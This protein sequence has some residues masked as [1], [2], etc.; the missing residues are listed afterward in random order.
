MSC[1]ARR[2]STLAI[3]GKV[4]GKV[5][6]ILDSIGPKD[7]ESGYIDTLDT[8]GKLINRKQ[9]G[10]SLLQKV[11]AGAI[12]ADKLPVLAQYE[13]AISEDHDSGATLL[14]KD[15]DALISGIRQKVKSLTVLNVQFAE[16]NQ[17]LTTRTAEVLAEAEI[18]KET[19]EAEV[20]DFDNAGVTDATADGINSEHNGMPH[21]APDHAGP[22]D[23]EG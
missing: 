19:V 2:Q 3:V 9:W 16:D 18:I 20:L 15:Y 1:L 21:H 11:T 4:H 6:Q 17:A 22:G 8:T 14:P 10:P 7:L 5:D 12:F 23:G 13:A